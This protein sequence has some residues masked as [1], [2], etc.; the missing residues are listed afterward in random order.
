MPTLGE[1]ETSSPQSISACCFLQPHR[2]LCSRPAP[3]C[4]PCQAPPSSSDTPGGVCRWHPT[5]AAGEAQFN[6]TTPPGQVRASNKSSAAGPWHWAQLSKH[7]KLLA[8]L[9][10][11]DYRNKQEFCS[12]HM[13]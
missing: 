12:H 5:A 11:E 7:I 4:V 2:A 6:T 13:N 8:E 1:Q 10:L 3:L 9:L